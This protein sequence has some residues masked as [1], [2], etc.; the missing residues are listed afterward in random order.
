[1]AEIFALLAALAGPG[2]VPGGLPVRLSASPFANFEEAH[3]AYVASRSRYNRGG[4]GDVAAASVVSVAF[5]SP[6]NGELWW[7]P[8][9]ALRGVAARPMAR[10]VRTGEDAGR[11]HGYRGRQY[12]L[13]TRSGVGEVPTADRAADA[14]L[15]QIWRVDGAGAG[16]DTPATLPRTPVSAG[17]TVGGDPA[18]LRRRIAELERQLEAALRENEELRKR[19]PDLEPLSDSHR[20][21][22]S[23]ELSMLGSLHRLFDRTPPESFNS[24][25]GSYFGARASFASFLSR[26][27]ENSPPSD[28]P[29]SRPLDDDVL[30]PEEAPASDLSMYPTLFGSPNPSPRPLGPPNRKRRASV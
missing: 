22:D 5:Q 11:L 17:R 29:D 9:D 13:V 6:V 14:S 27:Q 24:D 1:M 4:G 3:A 8:G 16:A 28:A 12:T 18:A 21:L 20:S 19:V 2:P 30:L 23:G 10:R 26:S 25:G 7:A 15:V